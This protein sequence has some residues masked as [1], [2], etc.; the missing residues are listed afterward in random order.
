MAATS[1]A[2][3]RLG[4]LLVEVGLISPD[5]LKTALDYQKQQGIRLGKALVELKLLSEEQL[6]EALEFQLGI[7][8][9][10][11]SRVVV[12]PEV[13]GLVAQP[14]ARRHQVLPLRRTGNKLVVAMADPFNV[15]AVDDLRQRTGLE[16]EVVLATETELTEALNR[17]YGVNG[18]A[19][20]VLRNLEQ[21]EPAA[22]EEGE[23]AESADKLRQLSDDA[24][25]VTLVN[26]IINQAVRDRASD[27]HIEPGEKDVRVR[28]RI[29]GMLHE[30]MR[31]PK[32]TQAGVVTRIKV[33]GRMDIAERRI[34]QDGQVKLTVDGREVELRIST[35]P[36]TFGE[37]AVLR[38]LRSTAN[39][40]RIGDLALSERNLEYFRNA[41]CH[42]HGMIL[43]TGPTG[44]GKT[45]TLYTALQEVNSPERNVV[46]LEDP[47]ERA[48]VG[49]N[50]V[51]INPKAGLTF[52]TALRALLRQDPDVIMVGEIRDLETA[53]LAVQ[54]ALTGHLVFSTLH[55]NDAVATLVRLVDMGV[56]PFLVGSSVRLI[57][58]Q[59][60]VRAV[61]ESCRE[62]YEATPREIILAGL[63]A[64]EEEAGA[65]KLR[66]YRG[67]GCP[68]CRQ[69]GYFDRLAIHEVLP[70]TRELRQLIAANAPEEA[71]REAAERA[72]MISLRQDGMAKARQGL[73]TVEEVLRV[74]F[75]SD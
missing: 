17:H 29:D 63:A 7:P 49:V 54:A 26:L 21:E 16:I 70:V 48:L 75:S 13:I 58:A 2:R 42:S 73:T 43:V 11:L 25:I 60:L 8:K 1:P 40:K 36:T 62:A 5:Q 33:L 51:Q 34:P 35:L 14:F 44:S 66:L 61:C 31:P 28:Y 18:A 72:G 30:V 19:E 3:R 37:K 64:T 53:R 71:V 27:I 65:Q 46:T 52:A 9:V 74:T 59:R 15:V 67:K 39:V 41:L 4:E 20:A 57:L 50:Q 22:E 12:S 38:I 55:T 10:D 23:E 68:R 45:T 69:T 24:P 56:E 6:V 47:V 32:R